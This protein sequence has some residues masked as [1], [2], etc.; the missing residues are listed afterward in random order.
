VILSWLL[1][2]PLATATWVDWFDIVL[3][4]GGIY[5]VLTW[6]RGTRA[7]QS[8]IG[9]GLLAGIYFVSEMVG[10]STLHWVLDHLFVYLVIALIILFQEDIRRALAQA[11]GTV[12]TR[13]KRVSDANLIEE[14]IRAVFAL[15]S[16]RIGALVALERS[17]SLERYI[18]G[19]HIIDSRVSTELL[20]SIFHPS[21][22]IHD[23]AVVIADQRIVA[24]GVF[25]PISH[26]KQ[27]PKV[28]GTR[29][30][31]AIGFTEQNDAVCLLVSEE[32]ATVAIVSGGVVTPVADENDLRQHLQE[33]LEL[34]AFAHAGEVPVV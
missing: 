12:Y 22:P 24:A 21:G 28:Y 14:V 33:F 32:R 3:M 4:T 17:A 6:I 23:G 2:S 5:L 18:D 26:S 20:V 30:R 19:A 29:H 1:D 15:S 11:G 10:I 16:R 27:L 31:A 7:M 13:S 34:A 9:L 8:L 25:L